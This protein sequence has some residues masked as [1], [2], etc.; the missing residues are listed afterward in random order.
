MMTDTK[1]LYVILFGVPQTPTQRELLISL[2][3]DP[4]AP[5][6]AWTLYSPTDD[7][8][9]DSKFLYQLSQGN[10]RISAAGTQWEARVR[11][12][13][14]VDHQLDE[15][16][17]AAV[18]TEIKGENADKIAE[19]AISVPAAQA[20]GL[21]RYNEWLAAQ[22]TPQT[23]PEKSENSGSGPVPQNDQSVP[24]NGTIAS[25]TTPVVPIASNQQVID[26]DTHAAVSHNSLFWLHGLFDHLEKH[27]GK[28]WAES[29]SEGRRLF[30]LLKDVVEL[31]QQPR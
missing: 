28:L 27:G 16:K 13:S 9:E 2:G 22:N 18:L 7:L 21:E 14:T 5:N 11:D 1:D 25:Q 15:A 26:T 8:D 10:L 30:P 24:Q 12:A 6:A 17:L 29:V 20:N 19:L 4:D 3:E 31:T 23:L